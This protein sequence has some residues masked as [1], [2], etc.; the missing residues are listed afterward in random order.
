MARMVKD[1][2]AADQKTTTE[3]ERPGVVVEPFR[4]ALH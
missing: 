1:P 3:I 4:P 2:I